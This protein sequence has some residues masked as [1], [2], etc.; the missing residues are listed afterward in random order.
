MILIIVVFLEIISSLYAAN[1]DWRQYWGFDSNSSSFSLT[2]DQFQLPPHPNI[3]DPRLFL[4]DRPNFNDTDLLRDVSIVVITRESVE[5]IEQEVA[6]TLRHRIPVGIRVIVIGSGDKIHRKKQQ[7]LINSLGINNIIFIDPEFEFISLASMRGLALPHLRTKYT[8]FINHD[9]HP[10]IVQGE[11]PLDWLR[12]LYYVAES[13]HDQY[14]G[15]VP[16]LAEMVSPGDKMSNWAG[17]GPPKCG[18]RN[19][20]PITSTSITDKN[21]EVTTIWKRNKTNLLSLHAE[22]ISL[23]EDHII[24]YNTRFAIDYMSNMKDKTSSCGPQE[25]CLIFF[26]SLPRGKFFLH[27][28]WSFAVF[29]VPQTHITLNSLPYYSYIRG[30]DCEMQQAF[31]ISNRIQALSIEAYQNDFRPWSLSFTDSLFM[32]NCLW[33]PSQSSVYQALEKS[34]KCGG[35]LP[36]PSDK[37]SHLISLVAVL[38]IFQLNQ[39]ELFDQKFN[40]I[41]MQSYLRHSRHSD[42][43]NPV[44]LTAQLNSTF[45]KCAPRNLTS[46]LSTCFEMHLPI[47]ILTLTIP[48]TSDCATVLYN[49]FAPSSFMI[50]SNTRDNEAVLYQATAWYLLRDIVDAHSKFLKFSQLWSSIRRRIPH[51]SLTF[52]NFSNSKIRFQGVCENDPIGSIEIQVCSPHVSISECKLAIRIDTM[53]ELTHIR[54]VPILQMGRGSL[55]SVLGKLFP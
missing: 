33:G 55:F 12:V 31:A 38:G 15:F 47:V 53:W 27:V 10:W 9:T 46:Y 22:A 39:F 13:A 8:L 25:T 5:Y 23:V 40:Y 19:F 26:S 41:Q 17:H 21:G 50:T 36:P 4:F 2:F 44:V 49:I 52:K 43:Q 16:L 7:I 3:D 54:H 11:D 18:N 20:P 37:L 32:K 28:P 51:K 14:V 29:H 35:V 48:L 42:L 45:S 24:M 30:F 34:G 6:T 1:L